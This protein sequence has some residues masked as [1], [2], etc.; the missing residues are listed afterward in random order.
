VLVLLAGGGLAAPW[1]DPAFEPQGFGSGLVFGAGDP[2]AGS[3]AVV[4][5]C[6]AASLVWLD[7]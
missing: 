3:E 7:P 5:A 4:G 1:A 2:A 6:A